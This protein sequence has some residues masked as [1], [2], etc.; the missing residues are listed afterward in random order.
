MKK[1]EPYL[2]IFSIFIIYT[3][4]ICIHTSSFWFTLLILIYEDYNILILLIII[5][6]LI[7]G[8]YYY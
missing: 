4:I 5:P 7:L 1:Y 2:R 8:Y 3:A 6:I